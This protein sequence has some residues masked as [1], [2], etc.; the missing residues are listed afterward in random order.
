LRGM[1]LAHLSKNETALNE[2]SAKGMQS[3]T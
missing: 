3:D 2:L 1:G